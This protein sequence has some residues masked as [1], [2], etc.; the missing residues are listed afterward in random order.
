MVMASR[1]IPSL[2]YVAR[3]VYASAPANADMDALVPL[4]AKAVLDIHVWRDAFRHFADTDA[5]PLVQSIAVPP[6]VSRLRGESE[7]DM[8]QRQAAAAAIH[9]H[10]D[11]CGT[12]DGLPGLCGLG[13][14][15]LNTATQQH[16]LAGAYATEHIAVLAGVLATNGVAQ[17]PVIPSIGNNTY[18]AFAAVLALYSFCVNL[19]DLRAQGLVPPADAGPLHVHLFTDSSSALAWLRKFRDANPVVSF[20]VHVFSH[21]QVVYNLTVTMSHVPG[22]L[23]PLADCL[24]RLFRTPYRSE[25]FRLLAATRFLIGLPPWTGDMRRHA[26]SPSSTTSQRAAAARTAAAA[27]PSAPLPPTIVFQLPCSSSARA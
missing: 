12:L 7:L 20:L 6:L 18:E 23:N 9:I 2:A 4:R 21:L 13:F 17:Q 26:L 19:A 14:S 24:S 8:G 22:K 27:P 16:V 15:V 11:S 10:G 3:G 1:F 5:S 25:A